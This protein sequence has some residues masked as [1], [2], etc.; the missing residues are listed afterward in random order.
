MRAI[1]AKVSFVSVSK[2]DLGL[3]EEER[4]AFLKGKSVSLLNAR[5]GSTALRACF[6]SGISDFG[7][8]REDVVSVELETSARLL[9]TD[10]MKGAL[11]EP[12]V[13]LVCAVKD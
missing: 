11:R 1:P 2:R 13:Q 3:I 12:V 10:Y 9:E 6:A 4:V 7:N 5:A 8:E